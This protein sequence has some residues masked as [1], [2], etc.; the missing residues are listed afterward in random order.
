MTDKTSCNNKD[1]ICQKFHDFILYSSY[2]E[3]LLT[4]YLLYIEVKWIKC[5]SGYS[6]MWV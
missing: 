5:I 2:G 4:F 3:I 6:C 1:K